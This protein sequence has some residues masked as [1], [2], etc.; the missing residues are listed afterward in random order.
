M[1]NLLAPPYTEYL[2]DAFS[3]PGHIIKANCINSSV[4]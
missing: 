1:H 4:L 3:G 2:L